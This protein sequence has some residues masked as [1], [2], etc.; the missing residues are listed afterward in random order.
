MLISDK[1][2]NQLNLIVQSMFGLNRVIDRIV[3]VMSVDFSCVQSSNLLHLQYAHKFPLLADFFS[4]IQDSYNI[5][6]DY[7]ETPRDNSNYNNLL[8]MFQKVLDKVLD[9]NKLIN[10]CIEICIE[11]GDYN[12]KSSL[13]KF[14]AD[15]YIH[16]IKQSII[17]RDKAKLYKDDVL[18]F[19]KDFPIFFI[20]NDEVGA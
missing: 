19:D 7:L 2:N 5:K 8:E 12:V 20:I 16:Y 15:I 10:D 14:L 3:S 9:A 1:T 4:E 11:E 6:T 17:L 13:E 18:R